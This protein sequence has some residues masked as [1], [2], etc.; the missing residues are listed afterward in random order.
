MVSIIILSYNTKDLLRNCIQSLYTHFLN[1]SFEIIVVDNASQDGSCEMVRK[2]FPKVTLVENKENFG[3]T[4][5][6]NIGVQHAKGTSVLFLNSDTMVQ[7]ASIHNMVTFMEKNSHVGIVGGRLQNTDGS[8]QRAYGTF[9]TLLRVCFMLFAGDKGE[10]LASHIN[11]TRSVDWVSG[12]CM[13]VRKSVFEQLHGFDENIFMYMED[14]EL[15]YRAKKQG[16]AVYFFPEATV[17]HLGQGS[18]NRSF[19]ILHI[20]K[21]LVY[22]YKKHKS[23][24]AYILVKKLLQLKAGIVIGIGTLTHRPTLVHTYKQALQAII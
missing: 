9:Y 5:G 15:C 11:D 22:F 23:F 6:N 16:F 13:L 14:M 1:F 3:F 2:V 12:G 18:S 20:Y 24:S 19:A 8:E 10:L 7:N 17:I 4:K 21:G